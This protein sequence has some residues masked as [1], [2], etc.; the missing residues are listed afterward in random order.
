MDACSVPSPAYQRPARRRFRHLCALLMVLIR[1]GGVSGLPRRPPVSAALSWRRR[2]RPQDARD[3]SFVVL[4]I[5][6]IFGRMAD[7]QACGDAISCGASEFVPLSEVG[8]PKKWEQLFGGG[9]GIRANEMDEAHFKATLSKLPFSWPHTVNT[10]QMPDRGLVPVPVAPRE[11]VK[12]VRQLEGT[13]SDGVASAGGNVALKD[14]NQCVGEMAI[15]ED[16]IQCVFESML[17]AT[18]SASLTRE[19]IGKVIQQWAPADGLVDWYTFVYFLTRA[20]EDGLSPY[21]D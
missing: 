17:Q 3:P 16:A 11:F 5:V 6:K 20:P 21:N 10:G 2:G 8:K 4:D 18:G 7:W 9:K 1:I 13:K 12:V 19:G 15:D 14:V